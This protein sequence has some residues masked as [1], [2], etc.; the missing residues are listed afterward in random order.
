MRAQREHLDEQR[1][2]LRR[3][4]A[5]H[6]PQRGGSADVDQR[7][8]DHRVVGV[9]ALPHKDG[10]PR[11]HALAWRVAGCRVQQGIAI[12]ESH[13]ALL[14]GFALGQLQACLVLAAGWMQARKRERPYVRG[15]RPCSLWRPSDRELERSPTRGA[16][17]PQGADL[18]L[19]QAGLGD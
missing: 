6:V 18:T 9:S 11:G 17:D 14:D 8:Q 19:D 7:Q 16:D 3:L 5:L 15:G 4:D 2:V 12:L 10:R 13:L 1:R